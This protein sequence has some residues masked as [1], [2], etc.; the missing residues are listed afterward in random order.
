MEIK[1]VVKDIV[2]PFLPAKT[3]FRFKPVSKEW[4]RRINGPFL[5][6]EQ[7]YYFRDLSGFFCQHD[8][9]NPTFVTLNENAYGVPT[10]SLTFLPELVNIVSSCNGLLLCQ[11]RYGNNSYFICNPASE[12]WTELPCPKFYHG[13]E[14]ATIL[15]FEPSALNIEAHYE[16]ICAVQILDHPI[17]SFEMVLEDF[18]NFIRG[19]RGLSF[20]GNNFYMNG[21]AYWETSQRKVVAFDLKNEFYQIISLPSEA[22]SS[23]ILTQIKG[24]LCYIGVSNFSGNECSI[25]ICSGMELSLK[26]L[27]SVRI[28]PALDH[29]TGYR[30]LPCPDG[31]TV[32]ILVRRFIYS[33]S[34][35]DRS[36]RVVSRVASDSIGA[37]K[38]LAYVNSLVHVA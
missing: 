9:E 4:Y 5:A 14:P 7:S 38:Y 25:M 11:G 35:G 36:I 32:M 28:G 31:D 27:M 19:I 16:L 21:I 23:G 22:P 37:D 24:E 26:R 1:D 3:L 6:H 8:D 17:I 20:T 30:V 34:I 29:I 18:R 2:L 15:A 33:F 13:Y 12:K 10:P